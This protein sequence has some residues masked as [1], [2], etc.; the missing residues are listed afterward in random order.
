MKRI[1]S[2]FIILSL[3]TTSCNE[4]E[5]VIQNE[6]RIE[7]S[8]FK[9]KENTAFHVLTE[10]IVTTEGYDDLEISEISGWKI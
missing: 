9:L 6:K 1:Y 7:I 2:L 3:I 10:A 5:S 4:D 8:S